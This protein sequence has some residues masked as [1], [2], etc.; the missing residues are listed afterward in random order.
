MAMTLGELQV[1]AEGNLRSDAIDLNPRLSNLHRLELQDPKLVRS[2]T[3]A[4]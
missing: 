1:L 4:Q 2:G 3:S